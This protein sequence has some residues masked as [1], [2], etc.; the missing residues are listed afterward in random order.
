MWECTHSEPRHLKEVATFTSR[1]LYYRKGEISLCTHCM[2]GCK[3]PR[4]G[5]YIVK[6]L[7]EG[8]VVPVFN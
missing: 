6:R 3:G 1:P 8:K 5:L 7:G 4:A 2:Q